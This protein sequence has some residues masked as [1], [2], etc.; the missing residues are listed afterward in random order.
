ML[1]PCPQNFYQDIHDE[2]KVEGSA[3]HVVHDRAE[4]FDI[5]TEAMFRYLQACAVSHRVSPTCTST[6][7]LRCPR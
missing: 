5:K 4:V 7:A 2:A 6:A 3:T 1:A